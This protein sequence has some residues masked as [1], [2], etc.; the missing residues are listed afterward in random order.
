MGS[1]VTKKNKWK[2]NCSVCQKMK[3]DKA[4]REAC[5]A[6]TYFDPNG[7]ESLLE[8]N[9]RYAQ[10]FKMPTLYRHMSRHQQD[11]IDIAEKLA[12]ANGIVSKNWQRKTRQTAHKSLPTAPGLDKEAIENTVAIVEGGGKP[13]FEKALDK[14]IKVG[15]AKLELGQIPISAANL[16]QAIKVKADIEMRTKDR[17]LDMLK[18]MFVGVPPKHDEQA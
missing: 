18:S 4:F 1:G 9:N 15:E 17:K 5:M 8:V 12:E 6:S 10:P 16:V 13:D 14:F 2:P 7:L 3:K 11:D